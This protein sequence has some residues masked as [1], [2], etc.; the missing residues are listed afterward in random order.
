MIQPRSLSVRRGHT[1]ALCG[2]RRRVAA[3]RLMPAGCRCSGF[4]KMPRPEFMSLLNAF[5]AAPLGKGDFPALLYRLHR[6]HC[7][8]FELY[9]SGA[10]AGDGSAFA[11]GLAC[12][13]VIHLITKLSNAV[14]KGN[15]PPPRPLQIVIML[16]ANMHAVRP[17]FDLL[18]Q[19]QHCKDKRQRCS[20]PDDVTVY[21]DQTVLCDFVVWS[22]SFFTFV[23]HRFKQAEG[24]L[25][26]ALTVE[27]PELQTAEAD[28]TFSAALE[29]LLK[30]SAVPLDSPRRAA[31]GSFVCQQ[32]PM[33]VTVPGNPTA[34]KFRPWV[35]DLVIP[36]EPET[37]P[38]RLGTLPLFSS[39]PS[40][41]GQ[42]VALFEHFDKAKYRGSGAL[43][44]A[45]S[46]QRPEDT[47]AAHALLAAPP[48]SMGCSTNEEF[49]ALLH[50]QD[51]RVAAESFASLV[52]P[53]W[54]LAS[55]QLYWQ[56]H[57]EA[58][59]A[60]ADKGERGNRQLMT[61]EYLALWYR[62]AAE[63][64]RSKPWHGASQDNY[65]EVNA[66]GVGRR[67][68]QIGGSHGSE[69]ALRLF[70]VGKEVD[71][72]ARHDAVL[73]TSK[74]NCAFADLKM[75]DH[76]GLDIA[77]ERAYPSLFSGYDRFKRPP[78]AELE[79]YRVLFE[80]FR[81]FFAERRL[82]PGDMKD[83]SKWFTAKM[84]IP[85]SHGEIR[86]IRV[87]ISFPPEQY[88]DDPALLP[89][90][91]VDVDFLTEVATGATC[92]AFDSALETFRKHGRV[93]ADAEAAGEAAAKLNPKLAAFMVGHQPL[94][95][96]EAWAKEVRAS[97]EEPKEG[98]K[99][100]S[101]AKLL[102]WGAIAYCM[103]TLN[104]W[105]MVPGALE[106]IEAATLAAFPPPP[107]VCKCAHPPCFVAGEHSKFKRC[108][109]C[110]RAFYCSG[111]CQKQD[112]ARHKPDCLKWRKEST[113]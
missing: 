58:L 38:V 88:R 56:L 57:A 55:Q 107:R 26:P 25:D 50:K 79:M 111:K 70:K 102:K 42:L 80:V 12:L 44:E 103:R 76:F 46:F 90:S 14:Y 98:E 45:M 99:P 47:V 81:D 85:A 59:T 73:F 23:N 74:T 27:V 75:I 3:A 104:A 43:L 24:S 34:L 92:E 11:K 31:R 29:T 95:L 113:A 16:L 110:K 39:R 37:P 49:D 35:V 72:T 61:E 15:N 28:P 97:Q 52:N 36:E 77:D 30:K 69:T 93:H 40:W 54:S 87:D 94:P 96:Y 53:D 82:K 48:I 17:L 1:L 10:P 86:P 65:I 21:P 101:E 32:V 6:I 112:W 108:S 105:R 22:H 2:W 64:Y 91:V 83:E 68:I 5:R 13:E 63:C 71:P 66:H 51:P 78:H 89:T 33:W 19:L 109:A 100:P 20:P 4:T 9:F 18:I 62:R 60:K 41:A 67:I 8:T 84:D 106:F 7:D